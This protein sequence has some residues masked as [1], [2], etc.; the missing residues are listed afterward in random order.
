MASPR[1]KPVSWPVTNMAPL[2]IG[3]NALYLIPGGVGGTEIYLRGLL[4]A[5]AQIDP[6]DQYFVFTNRE[7]GP[8]LAPQAPN[9]ELVPQGVSAVSRPARILWEQTILPLLARRRRNN[10]QCSAGRRIST[11]CRSFLGSS[12]WISPSERSARRSCR[13]MTSS[14][15]ILRVV[16]M[17]MTS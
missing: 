12:P 5:L 17:S 6:T 2:R 10:W 13:A 4:E 9:F 8:D 14:F 16:F 3:I 15:S 1:R 7:T 11:P